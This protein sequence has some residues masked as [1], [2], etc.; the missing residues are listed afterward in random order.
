MLAAALHHTSYRR[1]V[2]TLCS[3]YYTAPEVAEGTYGCL[4]ENGLLRP[5]R[6]AV[7]LHH[8]ISAVASPVPEP[9]EGESAS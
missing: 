4:I 3:V 7:A 1:I 8:A 5:A 6:T 9:S 2:A